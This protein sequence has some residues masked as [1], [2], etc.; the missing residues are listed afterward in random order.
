MSAG[1]ELFRRWVDQV[2]TRGDVGL[3]DE[4][5]TPGFRDRTGN[6]GVTPDTAGMKQFILRLRAAFPDAVFTT[7]DMVAEDDRVAARW[8]M[9]GT[10]TGEF[11][12]IPATGN[13]VTLAG[14]AF[15]RIQD[16]RL[17]ELWHPE[18]DMAALRQLGILPAP[19]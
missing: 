10:H 8:T 9:R 7:E 17:A 1:K 6:P 5:H 12:G 19:G 18:D 15:L 13:P 16:G 4:L 3:L 11:N 2:W 14:F